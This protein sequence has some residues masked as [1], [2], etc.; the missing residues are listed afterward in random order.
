M[1]KVVISS[2]FITS[3][4]LL[5][6]DSICT[7]IKFE[8]KLL[9]IILS[10]SQLRPVPW[11]Y[12]TI[13]IVHNLDPT[14][15]LLCCMPTSSSRLCLFTESPLD[16]PLSDTKCGWIHHWHCHWIPLDNPW[17]DIKHGQ[18][19]LRHCHW[20]P[21]DNPLSDI[22]RGQICHWHWISSHKWK[23]RTEKH[24]SLWIIVSVFKVHSTSIINI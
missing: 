20:I 21:L 1:G 22:K 18:T 9:F 23:I 11:A 10:P 15:I 2:F 19:H 4:Y 6:Q 7:S 17:S 3:R 14:S 12:E 13:W 16:N 5:G 8:V 24:I